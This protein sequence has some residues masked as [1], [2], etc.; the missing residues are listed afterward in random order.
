MN[1]LANKN[2]IAY[3]TITSAQTIAQ[4]ISTVCRSYLVYFV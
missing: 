2:T 4:T 1:D 3:K